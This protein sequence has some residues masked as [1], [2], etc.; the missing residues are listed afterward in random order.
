MT[1]AGSFGVLNDG[2]ATR[3]EVGCN[4]GGTARLRPLRRAPALGR[5][6]R[7]GQTAPR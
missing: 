6:G 3:F 7:V 2:V 5:A 1:P 4:L